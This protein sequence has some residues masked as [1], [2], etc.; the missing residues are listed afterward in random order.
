M[1]ANEFRGNAEATALSSEGAL[2]EIGGIEL[3][4]D[5]RE[6]PGGV[7]VAHD[8]S[9]ADDAEVSGI[10]IADGGDG[11]FGK[12]VGEILAL[13]TGAQILKRQHCHP[14]HRRILVR[15]RPDDLD[16]RNEAISP[17]GYGLKDLHPQ[18][19]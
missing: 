16:R 6:C 1:N 2:D 8:G 10:D 14:H 11:L 3:T 9:A 15:H 18:S 7:L 19:L 13:R 17:F 12:A 5:L 4:A